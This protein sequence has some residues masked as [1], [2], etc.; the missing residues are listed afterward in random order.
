MKIIINLRKITDEKFSKVFE[1][2]EFPVRIGREIDNEVI[3]EDAKK[4]VSRSHAKIQYDG[5]TF[6]LLDLGSA[7]FTYLNAE[8]ILPNMETEI[9]NGDVINIGDY[10][11]NIKIEQSKATIPIDDQRTMVFSSPF[12]QEISKI[13]EEILK[14]SEI[15]SLNDSPLKSELLRFSLMQNFD[16]IV[17][18]DV[19]QILSE[20]FADKFLNKRIVES[21]K[22]DSP[23]MDS[24][25][26]VKPKIK[27]ELQSISRENV[28]NS[29]ADYSFTKHFNESVDTLLDA[30]IK[31]IQGFLQFKQEFFGVT[32]YQTIPTGS[33]EE[34][35]KYLFNQEISTDEQKKRVNL[36]KE[37]T[38]KLLSHQIGLLKG[39][40]VSVTEGS[41]SMLQ[42]LD[43]EIIEKETASKQTSGLENFLPYLKKIKTLE[44]IK[45]SYKKY[46]SDPYYLEKKFFRPAFIKGYQKPLSTKN[47]AAED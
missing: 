47:E 14:L 35:K 42:S 10:E 21:N 43:P 6:H 15:Y 18:S 34:I 17:A 7:N 11:L 29:A 45:K 20:Y 12:N 27:S 26:S 23:S 38:Q 22:N 13:L 31:L 30:V 39:Y 24:S 3:L 19:S 33:L 4:I 16:K 2:T 46:I 37:E 36:I 9:E 8:K 1:F 28:S 40:K 5:E 32:I 41:Q 25:P 44:A